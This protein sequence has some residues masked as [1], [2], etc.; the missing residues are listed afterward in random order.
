MW[1]VLSSIEI[2]RGKKFKSYFKK[3]SDLFF[4]ILKMY[5]ANKLNF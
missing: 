3:N 1:K 2:I 5:K 4:K